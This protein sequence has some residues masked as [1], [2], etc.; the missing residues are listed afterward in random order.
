MILRVG[1]ISDTHGLLRPE[2]MEFLRGSHFIVHAGDICEPRILSGLDALA[3]VTAV[4]GNNDRGPW[5]EELRCAESLRVGEVT[6]HVVHDLADLD[7]DLS[8]AGIRVVVSG[9]SHKPHIEERNGILF[10]N[11]GSAGPRRFR[12][13]V[14]AAELLVEGQSV[15]ARITELLN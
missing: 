7:I 5:A 9:H 4:R 3:P 6:I 11:P 15:T 1:L 10:V 13:P 14:A 2:A 8:S 12:L